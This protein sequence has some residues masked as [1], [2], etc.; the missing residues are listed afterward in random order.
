[1]MK[2]RSGRGLVSGVIFTLAA[3][4]CFGMGVV[5]QLYVHHD[6]AMDAAPSDTHI[7]GNNNLRVAVPALAE[8]LSWP[9][10]LAPSQ[11]PSTE[12]SLTILQTKTPAA[13]PPFVPVFY[14]DILT[15]VPPLVQAWRQ[16]KVDWHQLLPKHD[17]SW[18]RFG[19]GQKGLRVLVAKE[20]Q[21]TDHL[22]MF[23]ESGLAGKYGKD[24]GALAGYLDW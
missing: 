9:P 8:P 12:K 5:F 20:E 2:A 15:F 19:K 3:I 21:L 7:A 11:P 24:H 6:A 14:R 17:S 23:Q 18:E 22:T 16:A 1:M 10:T 4:F 13:S